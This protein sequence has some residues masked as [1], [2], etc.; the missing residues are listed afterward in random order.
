MP[1]HLI[2]LDF[3]QPNYILCLLALLTDVSGGRI[4]MTRIRLIMRLITSHRT[5]LTITKTRKGRPRPDPGC[6]ATDDGLY[7]VK[8]ANYAVLRGVVSSILLVTLS[9]FQIFYSTVCFQTSSID[10][11]RFPSSSSLKVTPEFE[12]NCISSSVN[13]QFYF[14][15]CLT[16]RR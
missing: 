12:S 9:D 13:R 8:D 11:L 6:S 10:A 14:Q 16:R 5:Y 7:F 1:R 2:I 4:R 15:N 3:Y